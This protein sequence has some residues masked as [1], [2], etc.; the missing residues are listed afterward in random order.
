MTAPTV[1]ESWTASVEWWSGD[2]LREVLGAWRL[3]GRLGRQANL[4]GA[5]PDMILTDFGD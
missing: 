2:G 3:G 1:T 4:L 5:C